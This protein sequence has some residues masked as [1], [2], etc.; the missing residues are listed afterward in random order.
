MEHTLKLIRVCKQLLREE[1]NFTSS[2]ALQDCSF[3][4]ILFLRSHSGWEYT[5]KHWLYGE[6]SM[7][8][9]LIHFEELCWL[10]KWSVNDSRS[11]TVGDTPFLREISKYSAVPVFLH[12]ERKN[13]ILLL[14][15]LNLL[16]TF[17][18]S[19]R[20]SPTACLY[21]IIIKW[22]RKKSRMWSEPLI[23][24]CCRWTAV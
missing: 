9:K 2:V 10:N 12:L 17:Q 4:S 23:S 7:K 18:Y 24:S 3:P 20:N 22:T 6:I 11:L 5:L 8:F 19:C 14:F 1:T 13:F 21:F 16:E 15:I